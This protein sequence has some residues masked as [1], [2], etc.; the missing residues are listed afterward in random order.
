MTVDVRVQD[1][2]RSWQKKMEKR[3]SMTGRLAKRLQTKMNQIIPEKVH[4]V[5]TTS[6]KKMVHAT[7]I[8][9]EYTTSVKRIDHTSFE[10]RERRV[11]EA[12]KKYKKTAAVE[13]AGTGAGGIL[14]GMADFPLLL[15][16]KMKFLFETASCY[17]YDV[18]NFRERL[19]ILY[20]FQL[21]FS[22]EEKRKEVYEIVSN[23]DAYVHT[24]PTEEEYL[25]NI[26][27]KEFQ[28]EYRD[29]IDLVKMLQLIPGVGAIVGAAAN[30]HF[31]DV[32]G[33]TAKNGY[34]MRLLKL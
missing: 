6:I 5:V 8:G 11:D 4:H 23:W 13:G 34:R 25:E 21:A 19:F 29:H 31:L 22:S 7:L 3:Q 17:G 24:I 26:N 33:E 2:L 9:S 18:N 15:G 28:L 20:L 30:Y 14:L 12:I 27:W 1:E 32:L 10:E 16:I